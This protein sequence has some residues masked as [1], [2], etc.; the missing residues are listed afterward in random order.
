MGKNTTVA[1]MEAYVR[2]GC[3]CEAWPKP[4]SYHEGFLDGYEEAKLCNCGIRAAMHGSIRHA[5]MLADDLV[6]GCPYHDPKN[7]KARAGS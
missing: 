3:E 7:A 2:R 6:Y 1:E 5:A 4:C